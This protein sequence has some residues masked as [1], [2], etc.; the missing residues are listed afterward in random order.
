M[1]GPLGLREGFIIVLHVALDESGDGDAENGYLAVGG[2]VFKYPQQQQFQRRWRAMLKR[3]D[4]PY[5]HMVDCNSKRGVF[6]HLT[7]DECDRCA[8]Q[9]IAISRETISFGH[10]AIVSQRVYKT[11]L[12]DNGFTCDAYSFLAFV[13]IS[14][15]AKWRN[16]HSPKRRMNLCIEHGQESYRQAHTILSEMLY[17]PRL[18]S[19][20]MVASHSWVKKEESVECQAADL[21]SWHLRSAYVNREK[22]KGTRRDSLALMVGQPVNITNLDLVQLEILRLKLEQASGSLHNAAKAMLEPLFPAIGDVMLE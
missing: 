16:A 15:I 5:F 2:Y 8:R 9:A 21:L 7:E 4:L 3:Y 22:R 18:K 19:R 20:F 13:A 11:V 6:A 1:L 14:Q 10:A 17:D 12:Q